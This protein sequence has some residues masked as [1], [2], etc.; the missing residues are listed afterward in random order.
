[1]PR[2]VSLVLVTDFFLVAVFYIA[3]SLRSFTARRVTAVDGRNL[4]STAIDRNRTC[5]NAGNGLKN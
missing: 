2:L 5:A 4:P 3:F 1:M